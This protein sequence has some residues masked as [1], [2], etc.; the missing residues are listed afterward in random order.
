MSDLD[1]VESDTRDN[2]LAFVTL[3][4]RSIAVCER[5][6][7][8]VCMCCSICDEPRTPYCACDMDTISQSE[9][10]DMFARAGLGPSRRRRPAPNSPTRSS[11]SKSRYA[12]SA[13]DSHR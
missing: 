3:D 13:T 4:G 12:T 7:R 11:S 6:D 10:R 9:S 1:R 8:E 2:A 5:C